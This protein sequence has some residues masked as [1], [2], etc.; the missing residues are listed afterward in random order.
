MDQGAYHAEQLAIQRD[1]EAALQH[2]ASLGLSDAEINLLAWASGTQ[3]RTNHGK[4]RDIH[5]AEAPV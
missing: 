4:D 2:A 5:E 3:I 1:I